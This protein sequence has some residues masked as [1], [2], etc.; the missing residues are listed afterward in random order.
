MRRR[1][2]IRGLFMLPVLLCVGG[3][4]WSTTFSCWVTYSHHLQI[5]GCRS[6]GG[7]VGVYSLKTFFITP[8]GWLIATRHE[9]RACFWPP[10]NLGFHIGRSESSAGI[11]HQIV[12]P[13]W[14]LIL[15]FSVVLLFLWPKIQPTTD[16]AT[17]FPVQ[18]GERRA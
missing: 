2:I 18:T 14:F 15:V 10:Q 12:I 9:E 7:A 17:A 3:W 5:F 16:P 6:M 8:D 4:G 1:W 13:Y 11:C